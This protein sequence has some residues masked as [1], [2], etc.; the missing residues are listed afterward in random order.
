MWKTSVQDPG[1][2]LPVRLDSTDLG[3]VVTQFDI[4]ER[5]QKNLVQ[6]LNVIMEG[7][8]S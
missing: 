1:K 5:N 7:K 6:R 8:H 4:R 2:S 3:G